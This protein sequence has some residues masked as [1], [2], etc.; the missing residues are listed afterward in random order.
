[1]QGPPARQGAEP[2]DQRAHGRGRRQIQRERLAA[3]RLGVA[4]EQ[5]DPY[6]EGRDGG[7]GHASDA[8][9]IDAPPT[10][11]SRGERLDGGGGA[12]RPPSGIRAPGSPAP[13]PRAAGRTTPPPRPAPATPCWV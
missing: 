8:P 7:E 11:S 3:E 1:G 12:C 6:R 13:A 4:R 2:L 9:R 5:E 10:T